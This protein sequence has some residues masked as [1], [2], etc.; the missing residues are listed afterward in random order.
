MRRRGGLVLALLG[1]ALALLAA[2]SPAAP[3]RSAA[4]RHARAHH[5]CAARA[6]AHRRGSR[7]LPPCHSSRRPPHPAPATPQAGAAAPATG[8]TTSAAGSGS[9]Q[10]PSS[11]G[12]A[13]GAGEGAPGGP[14]SVPHIQV[15]A[16]EYRFTLS[17]TAVPH[18]KVIFEFVNS[19][20]DEHNLNVLPGE[21]PPAGSFADTPAKGLRDQAMELRPG[22]YTLFCSLPEHEQKGMRSTLVVE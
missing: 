18:G 9:S 15:T 7:R 1:C 14:P 11:T 17:R 12:G 21:G 4:R 13:P 8:G 19:G 20:Q 6:H 2:L 10:Q 5:L 16:I 3:S 22:T